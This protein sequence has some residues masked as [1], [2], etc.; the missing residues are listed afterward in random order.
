[1]AFS[2]NAQ[3]KPHNKTK[4]IKSH[5][6]V[7]KPLNTDISCVA[8]TIYSE[9]RGEPLVGQIAVGQTIINRSR[10]VFNKPVC[11]VIKNQ[12]TRKRI[13]KGDKEHFNKL[14]NDILLNKVSNPIGNKDSFDSHLRKKHKHGSV[15]I[16]HHYFYQSLKKK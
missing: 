15:R 4:V 7:T 8:E 3:P 10:K 9:A 16:G 11:N 6:V 1:V 5:K 2:C 12:Y 14:A 13:P